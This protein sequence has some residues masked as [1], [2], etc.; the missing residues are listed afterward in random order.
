MPVGSPWS[1]ALIRQLS[2]D[3][4]LRE[5]FVADQ[6]RTKVALQIRALREQLG[7]EWSQTE[8][9]RRANTTQSVISR[10]EDPDYGR[11]TL[12]TLIDV[13]GA[14]DLPLLVEFTE[15]EEW[16]ART[17]DFSAGML[18]RDSFDPAALIDS[19]RRAQEQVGPAARRAAEDQQSKQQIRNFPAGQPAPLERGAHQHAKTDFGVPK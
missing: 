19:A 18:A 8:L 7:R 16:F 15:W 14:F 13:A 5:E 17:S 2:E 11:L 9:A 3:K 12:Q 4:E 6:V 1:E 10:I